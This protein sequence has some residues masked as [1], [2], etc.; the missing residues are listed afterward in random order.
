[1]NSENEAS[2]LNGNLFTLVI[3]SRWLLKMG[4]ISEKICRK[5]RNIHFLFK[6]SSPKFF[7]FNRWCAKR[8]WSQNRPQT[9]IYYNTEKMWF[10][11]WI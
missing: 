10:A 9:A 4:D 3:T 1:L 2:N 11:F 7:P 5:I 8:Q 6:K